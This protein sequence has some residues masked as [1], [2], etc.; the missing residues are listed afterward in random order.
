MLHDIDLGS[1]FTDLTSKTLATK[2]KIAKWN[3]IKLKNLLQSKE[4]NPIS[5]L[6]VFFPTETFHPHYFLLN[7]ITL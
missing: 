2:A 5:H 1:D 4:N 7:Y 6:I 3:Y